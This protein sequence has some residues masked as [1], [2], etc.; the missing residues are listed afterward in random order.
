M[1]ARA[2]ADL[3]EGVQRRYGYSPN[4][5]AKRTGGAVGRSAVYDF[6]NG[7]I[8]QLPKPD[9]LVALA[10]ALHTSVGVLLLAFLRDLGLELPGGS[11]PSPEE[12]ILADPELD[13]DRRDI[14]LRQ[15]E[16]FRRDLR[17]PEKA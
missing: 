11:R 14:L 5:I 7:K 6:R 10:R 8:K 13:D 4:D 12:A 17:G 16:I 9:E 2:V 15:L 1:P 3:I